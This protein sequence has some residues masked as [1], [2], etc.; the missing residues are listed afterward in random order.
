MCMHVYEHTRSDEMAKRRKNFAQNSH[1]WKIELTPGKKPEDVLQEFRMLL[2][3]GPSKC[4]PRGRN[5]SLRPATE[6]EL[7]W[8][9]PE[10]ALPDDETKVSLRLTAAKL[11]SPAKDVAFKCV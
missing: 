2:E 10:D 11:Y 6:L 5:S 7:Q 1:W 8:S 9:V 3:Q 4:Q